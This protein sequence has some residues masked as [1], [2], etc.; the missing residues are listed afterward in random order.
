[1]QNPTG[2]MSNGQIQQ[3]YPSSSSH[4]VSTPTPL[5]HGSP[6][7]GPGTIPN[8]SVP[9]TPT[10]SYAG[11]N[12]GGTGSGTPAES[13]AGSPGSVV[14]G[15]AE[16]VSHLAISLWSVILIKKNPL[17]LP[18]LISARQSSATPVPAPSAA[19]NV[20]RPRG[21]KAAEKANKAGGAARGSKTG[22]A[23]DKKK[24]L[25]QG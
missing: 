21:K 22:G 15:L 1:M 6:L 7:G 24:R 25:K 13:R 16:S 12:P 8:T 20:K 4:F 11:I 3:T 14:G 19:G 17:H 23:A 9:P 2:I 10:L 18:Q 5:N